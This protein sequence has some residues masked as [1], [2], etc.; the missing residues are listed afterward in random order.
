MWAKNVVALRRCKVRM[1]TLGSISVS[2]ATA[3]RARP[4][5]SA[6]TTRPRAKCFSPRPNCRSFTNRYRECRA[7]PTKS[8]LPVWNTTFRLYRLM[9]PR[10]VSAWRGAANL[11]TKAQS[12][13]QLPSPSPAIPLRTGQKAMKW[14]L[15]RTPIASLHHA[16]W[17]SWPISPRFPTMLSSWWMA[18]KYSA[19]RSTSVQ[20]SRP[21]LLPPRKAIPSSVGVRPMKPA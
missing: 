20:K 4:S 15:R 10:A 17:P 6:S 11:S 1:V 13:R 12:L 7:I 3:H 18:K 16:T 8:P 2:T 14:F 19:A 21:L 5:S 9:R